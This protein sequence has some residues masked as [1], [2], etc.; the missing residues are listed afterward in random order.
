[1]I[2]GVKRDLT[3]AAER[4]NQRREKPAVGRRMGVPAQI[5]FPAA[6]NVQRVPRMQRLNQRVSAFA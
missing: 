6:E 4:Q 1:M 3:H 5:H 2:G